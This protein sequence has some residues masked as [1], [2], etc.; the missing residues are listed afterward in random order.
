MHVDTII[1]IMRTQFEMPVTRGVHCSICTS[2]SSYRH[3]KHYDDINSDP[4]SNRGEAAFA[5]FWSLSC[6]S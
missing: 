1:I 2:T 6:S 5:V 4:S 3:K